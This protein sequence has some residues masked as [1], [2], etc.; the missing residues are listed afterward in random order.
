MR[1]WSRTRT[2]VAALSAVVLPILAVPAGASAAGFTPIERVA[3]TAPATPRVASDADGHAVLAWRDGTRLLA[4]TRAPGAT[5]SAATELGTSVPAPPQAAVAGD[6]TAF[7][8]YVDGGTVTVAVRP[9]GGSWSTSAVGSAG[10][11]QSFSLAVAPDGTAYVLWLDGSAM[12]LSSRAPGGGFVPVPTPAAPPSGASLAG[13]LLAAESG[14]DLVAAWGWSQLDSMSMMTTNH[15]DAARRTGGSW[16]AVQELDV[17]SGMVGQTASITP[18]AIATSAT[19]AAAVGWS[20]S[21]GMVAMPMTTTLKLAWSGA[22]GTFEAPATLD[23]GTGMLG[24]SNVTLDGLSLAFDG[25]RAVAAWRSS[26]VQM[27]PAATTSSVRTW[28]RAAGPGGAVSEVT[29]VLTSST[30]AIGAP[31]LASRRSNGVFLAVPRPD[32]V[33]VG[34]APPSGALG[35]VAPA[36]AG[37]AGTPEVSAAGAGGEDAVV[38]LTA[39]TDPQPFAGLSVYDTAPPVLSGVTV[40][41]TATTAAPVDVSSQAVDR[42]QTPTQTWDF[43]DGTT[44]TGASASHQYAAP[45]AYTVTAGANDATSNV[46]PAQQRTIVV[47]APA[48]GGGGGTGGGGT[49]AP[50][51]GLTRDTFATVAFKALRGT[52]AASRNF[53]TAVLACATKTGC[54]ARI[55]V[56]TIKDK[57]IIL[58][59]ATTAT[60]PGGGRRTVMLRLSSS[61]LRGLRRARHL[62]ARIAVTLSDRA[63]RARTVTRTLRM[64]APRH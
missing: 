12:H 63:G 51:D 20:T 55:A 43:G 10:P 1:P 52:P 35:S 40:P 58:V 33:A 25:E 37:L 3:A 7:V 59:A 57:H 27:A 56:A 15:L 53:G 28:S 49:P 60:V 34:A 17:L 39:P 62:T 48:P 8:A 46:A 23:A 29:D 30:D 21:H 47:T 61:G 50:D 44:A 32:G 19:K 11:S 64:T 26:T 4:A 38:A 2:L 13:V 45:G 16:G 14:G 6:G 18:L 22:G 41:A 36:L 5:L 42:W 9:P 31:A 54:R 24:I